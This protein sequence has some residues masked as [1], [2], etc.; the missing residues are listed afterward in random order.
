MTLDELLRSRSQPQTGVAMAMADAHQQLT[1]L[2]QW[3]LLGDAIERRFSF[4]H[5]FETLAFVNALAYVVHHEDHHP[6]LTV[7]YN[8]C[9]VRFNTHSV[10]G[11]SINDFICAAKID[12]LHEQRF[13]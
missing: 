7:E 8:R 12:A 3:S 10:R 1:V 4:T 2:P 5:Y 11:L 9:T 13:G 6:V